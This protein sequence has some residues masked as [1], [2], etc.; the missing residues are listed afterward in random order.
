MKESEKKEKEK[1]KKLVR[2]PRRT[3]LPLRGKRTRERK[4]KERM[5]VASVRVVFVD[6]G[7]R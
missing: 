1:E 7:T 4:G 5:R 3:R 6:T 2:G